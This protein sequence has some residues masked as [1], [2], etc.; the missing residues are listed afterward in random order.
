MVVSPPLIESQLL[1]DFCNHLS[2]NI[3]VIDVFYK[4]GQFKPEVDLLADDPILLGSRD[5]ALLSTLKDFGYREFLERYVAQIRIL[6]SCFDVFLSELDKSSFEVFVAG[7]AHLAPKAVVE[8]T[9]QGFVLH[10][11]ALIADL[12]LPIVSRVHEEILRSLVQWLEILKALGNHPESYFLHAKSATPE[13]QF[14]Q[15]W[16]AQKLKIPTAPPGSGIIGV[17]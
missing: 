12:I 13:S 9:E 17:F 7:F 4:L 8:E 16:V 2:A 6:P 11:A 5:P 15:L 1:A 10:T 3:N 14:I